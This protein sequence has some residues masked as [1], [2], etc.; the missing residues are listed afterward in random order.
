M[1]QVRGSHLYREKT[2]RLNIIPGFKHVAIHYLVYLGKSLYHSRFE[3]PQI[4]T[5]RHAWMLVGFSRV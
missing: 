5:G 1:L 2:I 3:F 4:S